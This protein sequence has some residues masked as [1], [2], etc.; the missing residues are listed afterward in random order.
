MANTD[1][2]DTLRQ[3]REAEADEAQARENRRRELDDL[4]WLLAHPQ[5][6]RIAGRVLS[7]TGVFRS[8]FNHSGS[9]MAWNEGRRQTGLWLTAELLEAAP[10]G[11]FKVLKQGQQ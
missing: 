10:E 8:S 4:R 2:T 7:E 11:Y 3:E 1:P 9:V 6:R 5:G